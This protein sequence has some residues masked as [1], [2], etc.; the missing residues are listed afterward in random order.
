MNYWIGCGRITLETPSDKRFYD[1]AGFASFALLVQLIS[2]R[3]ITYGFSD[4][5][6]P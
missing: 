3:I 5:I 6:L 1:W 2:I 4:S